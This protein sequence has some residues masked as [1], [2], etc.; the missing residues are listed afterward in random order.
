MSRLWDEYYDSLTV[1]EK[2]AIEIYESPEYPQHE[3]EVRKRHPRMQCTCTCGWRAK[4]GDFC[5]QCGC[6]C[7]LCEEIPF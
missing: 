5:S 7:L 1:E 6:K 4:G 2:I 3:P